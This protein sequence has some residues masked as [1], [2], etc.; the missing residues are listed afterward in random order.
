MAR[1]KAICTAMSRRASP[2]QLQQGLQIPAENTLLL[3]LGQALQPLHP[4][5]GRW[6]PRHERP[7]AAEH[8]A[9]GAHPIEQE[10]ER[11]L[12]AGHAV[13]VEAA[14]VRARRLLDLLARFG[15]ALPALVDP[16][17]REAGR[18]AP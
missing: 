16:P 13:V 5:N 6:V 4:G 1:S 18:A 7:V 17:H 15:A 10:A 3:V 14:L 8:H 9:V 2:L 11:L 12:A